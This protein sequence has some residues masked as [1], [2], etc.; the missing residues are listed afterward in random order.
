M[1]DTKIDVKM[2]EIHGQG[3]SIMR[4]QFHQNENITINFLFY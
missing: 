2:V 4:L 3:M 1:I